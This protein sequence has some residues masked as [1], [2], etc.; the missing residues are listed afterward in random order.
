MTRLRL[1]NCHK[2]HRIDHATNLWLAKG[3]YLQPEIEALRQNRDWH[4]TVRSRTHRN[5]NNT[6]DSSATNTLKGSHDD[7]HNHISADS[8]EHWS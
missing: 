2:D 4:I 8:A 7:D 1:N 5:E 3:S 6:E